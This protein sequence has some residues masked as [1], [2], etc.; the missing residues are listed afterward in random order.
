MSAMPRE[1]T[2]PFAFGRDLAAPPPPPAPLFTPEQVA[3]A[4]FAGTPVAGALLVAWNLRRAHR[5][6]ALTALALGVGAIALALWL[7]VMWSGAVWWLA[8]PAWTMAFGT[9]A[10][11]LFGKLLPQAGARSPWVAVLVVVAAL[12]ALAGA[13]AVAT[14]LAPR[15]VP[16]PV[17]ILFNWTG[18]GSSQVHWSNGGTREDALRV[19]EAIERAGL[20][21]DDVQLAL[22][23]ARDDGLLV[24]RIRLPDASPEAVGAAR[25]LTRAV[26]DHLEPAECVTG[27]IVNPGDDTLAEGTS[28]R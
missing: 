18:V 19:G 4:T 20:V 9:G 13:G 24:L 23:V 12:A 17:E 26:A 1:P 8:V 27:R 3:A 10:N 25:T 6:G 22:T 11:L 14:R 15:A 7:D 28:C 16:T 2:S 5:R 21:R